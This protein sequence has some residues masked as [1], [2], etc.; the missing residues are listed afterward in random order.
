M[1]KSSSGFLLAATRVPFA[2]EKASKNP[3]KRYPS[4]ILE[5]QP[6][7]NSMTSTGN[8]ISYPFLFFFFL[9]WATSAPL[10]SFLLCLEFWG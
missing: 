9:A 7:D 10:F 5:K 3:P 4:N 6:L 1:L 8:C 2:V